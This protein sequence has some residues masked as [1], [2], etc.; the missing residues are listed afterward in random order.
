V[1]LATAVLA[2]VDVVIVRD[3]KFPEGDF[4]GTHVTGPYDIN[5]GN[6][7]GLIER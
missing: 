2:G 4:E 1:H 6:L 5:E 7:L 3:H